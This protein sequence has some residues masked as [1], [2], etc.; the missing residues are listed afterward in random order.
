[1]PFVLLRVIVPSWQKPRFIT[2]N[3]PAGGTKVHE[4]NVNN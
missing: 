4:E 3:P 2:T 1:M